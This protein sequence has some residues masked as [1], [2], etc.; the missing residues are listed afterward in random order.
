MGLKKT[1]QAKKK[2]GRSDFG[3][4]ASKQ[5]LLSLDL[6]DQT[7]GSGLQ[8]LNVRGLQ[9]LGAADD[10][11][12][13]RLAVVQ[14]LVAIRLDRGEVDENV[15]S[16]LA[17]DEAKA[18]AGVK[19]LDCSLFFAHCFLLFS[20]FK[21]IWCFV[22]RGDGHNRTFYLA[23]RRNELRDSACLRLRPSLAV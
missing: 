1:L 8:R 16:G 12:L 11:E 3:P 5:S 18:L 21:A 6:K 9:A 19:P 7:R 20:S 23:A 22:N 4:P 15:L 14:R 2:S 17:L 13:D 10:F